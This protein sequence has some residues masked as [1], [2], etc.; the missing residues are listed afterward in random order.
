[1]NLLTLWLNLF[2]D[3]HKTSHCSTGVFFI[4]IQCF[5]MCILFYVSFIW[6]HVYAFTIFPSYICGSVFES[7]AVRPPYYCT[8]TCFRSFC[9]WCA[10]CVVWK[11]K[12][13][14]VVSPGG[15][16]L[17]KSEYK[18]L[19]RDRR[20]TS[21]VDAHVTSKVDSTINSL[22]LCPFPGHF[23]TTCFVGQVRRF[24]YLTKH[25]QFRSYLNYTVINLVGIR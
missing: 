6:I 9:T 11:P 3:D 20:V 24:V 16:E 18:V 12:K 10:N 4:H 25:Q 1:M 5:L 23:L 14:I 22:S 17:A 15:Q 8:S 13:K 7:G 19:Y 2:Q 21:W